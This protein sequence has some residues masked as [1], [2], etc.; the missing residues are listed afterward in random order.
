MIFD[1]DA[2]TELRMLIR[3]KMSERRYVHTLG[4]E[5]MA[6]YLGD[7]IIPKH[8]NELCV[9]ALLHDITKELTY[10]EQVHLLEESEISCTKENC[11]NE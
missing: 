10:E 4:V 5:K 9:A 3:D 1:N 2:I 7:I 6:K 11:W 8:T